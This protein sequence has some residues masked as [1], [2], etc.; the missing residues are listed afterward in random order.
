MPVQK[1]TITKRRDSGPNGIRQNCRIRI[2]FLLFAKYSAT[3]F[4]I[5]NLKVYLIE[6]FILYAMIPYILGNKPMGKFSEQNI[7]FGNKPM[8]E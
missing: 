6:N 1:S 3:E 5:K 8:R 2:F 4:L 7:F